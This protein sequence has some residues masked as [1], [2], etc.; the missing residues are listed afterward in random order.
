MARTLREQA[1]IANHMS[2]T[3]W[4]GELPHGDIEL[5]AGYLFPQ[6][7]E[8]RSAGEM[9]L[10]HP[11]DVFLQTV[12]DRLRLKQIHPFLNAS[13]LRQQHTPGTQLAQ[14]RPVSRR[15]GIQHHVRM[16]LGCLRVRPMPFAAQSIRTGYC[17][18]RADCRYCRP[19]GARKA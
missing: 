2:Q 5:A 3:R 14:L 17:Q 8:L 11:P 10:D 9:A 6:S 12:Q 15:Q 19:D 13:Q 4:R 7:R 1:D 18:I 16:L